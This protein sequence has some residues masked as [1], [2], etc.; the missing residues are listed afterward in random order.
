MLDLYAKEQP[1]P[2]LCADIFFEYITWAIARIS[3]IGLDHWTDTLEA[4]RAV[5]EADSADPLATPSHTVSQLTKLFKF[6]R[7]KGGHRKDHL[8]RFSQFDYDLKY[9]NASRRYIFTERGRLVLGP[10]SVEIGDEVWILG[11]SGFPVV[12]RPVPSTGVPRYR[13]VGQAYVH[14]VMQGE[15]LVGGNVPDTILLV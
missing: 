13:F 14:G 1:A 6:A 3:S 9:T 11:G 10:L 2:R 12:L 5:L 15:A 7:K 4:F 8:S